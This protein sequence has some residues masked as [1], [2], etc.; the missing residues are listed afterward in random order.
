MSEPPPPSQV[1]PVDPGWT[2]PA[3]ARPAGRGDKLRLF[4][5]VGVIVAFLGVVLWAV[6]DNVSADDLSV[7]TC[8]DVPE[9]DTDIST[10][11]RRDCTAEHDAEVIH[12]AEYT[13]ETYPISLSMD[14]FIDEECLPAFAT[15]VGEDY[16]TN[17][18]LSIGYFY[19]NREGWDGGDRTVTC[20]ADRLDGSKIIQSVKGAAE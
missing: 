3:P 15:Y 13:G 14:R 5:I 17:E 1:T 6:R 20:Y 9:R 18:D 19:P 11:T 10:V 7:G 16:N 2:T 12:V 4:L 8:F